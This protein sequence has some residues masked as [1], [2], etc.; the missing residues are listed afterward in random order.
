MEWQRGKVEGF[1]YMNNF[2]LIFVLLN[3]IFWR[4]NK[5]AQNSHFTYF[6]N[7]PLNRP[8][9]L[10]PL[11]IQNTLRHA[12]FSL[13]YYYYCYYY[14]IKISYAQHKTYNIVKNTSTSHDI[15]TK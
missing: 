10:L 1:E 11:S 3:L 13:F 14:F 9:L 6:N 4:T 2:I 8:S 12:N 5:L 7:L 15:N